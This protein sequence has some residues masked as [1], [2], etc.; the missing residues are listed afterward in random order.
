MKYDVAVI[1]GGA[2]G[3][4][5]AG[6][7]GEK[8]AQVILIE[9]NNQLGV[10]LLMTGGTRCNLTNNIEDPKALAAHY[11]A[12]GRFLISAFSRFGALD[13]IRFFNDRGVGT[14]MEE[15][16][17]VF[18]A[19]D[20]GR[21]VLKALVDYCR[22]GNVEIMTG[23]A[24]KEF[25]MEDDA[26]TGSKIGAVKLMN[27]Q[28]ITAAQYVI[29][30]GG[31]SYPGSGST[32][33]A[34]D[35]LRKMGHAVVAPSPALVPVMVGEGCVADLE[36]LSQ[37]DAAVSLWQDDK[38]IASGRGDILFTAAGLSGPAI[39]NISRFI[40][41]PLS[42]KTELSLD[43]FPDIEKPALDRHLREIFSGSNKNL[44]NSLV[45]LIAPR[46]SAVLGELAVIDSDKKAN[47]YTKEERQRLVALLKDFRF[48]V[49]A[50]AGYDKAMITAGG[51]ELKE[52]DP[53]DMRSK[54]IS[55]L[56]VVGEALDIAGPTG[57]FNLQACWSTGYVAGEAAVNG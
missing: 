41:L 22:Q 49:K 47:A 2:S 56:C 24:A 1:G 7:A 29:A 17:R 43:F 42:S 57:G 25:L 23:A 52:V 35:W 3:L 28:E 26:A 51:L 38:K 9:K 12:A 50:L 34:Y 45:S 55:N 11:G 46:L 6:R 16:N 32:G 10:K 4:M 40:A 36:G 18:P 54:L 39:L 21:D 20:S 8:G 13:A 19:S 30:T 37:R 53:K 33:D 31:R 15:N 48:S 44:K 14:K 5:A 27:G